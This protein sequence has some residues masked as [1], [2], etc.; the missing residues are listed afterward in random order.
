MTDKDSSN[1]IINF[2]GDIRRRI[3]GFKSKEEEE[4]YK[5]AYQEELEKQREKAKKKRKKR[6]KK[7]AK[8]KAKKKVNPDENKDGLSPSL[9]AI[10]DGAQMLRK[11]VEETQKTL[12]P[13][14]DFAEGFT[15]EAAEVLAMPKEEERKKKS[16]KDKPDWEF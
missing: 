14:G 15:E 1:P 4:L 5:E 3:L 9:K 13:L 2:L 12:E 11:G 6:L 7:T 10:K 16:D 8:R